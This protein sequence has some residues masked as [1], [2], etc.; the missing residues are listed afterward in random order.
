MLARIYTVGHSNHTWEAF[1]PLLLDNAIELLVD[2]RSRP[3][4]RFARFSNRRT[5]PGLL[6]SIGIDY[7]FMG[8][9][10]GGRPE[11]PSMYDPEG[12]P[13]YGKMRA[14][15]EFQIAIDELVSVASQR[16]TVIL[17]SEGDPK[18]CHRRLL[19]GPP[20]QAAGLEL[21]HVMRDGG[22]SVELEVSND[23]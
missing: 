22:V 17:C 6:E 10:L 8:R 13:D 23:G 18:L 20:L 2:V 14:M 5:F 21:L 12:K 16:R 3:V 4:S 9:P 1:S 7:E 19:L 11:D 15:D